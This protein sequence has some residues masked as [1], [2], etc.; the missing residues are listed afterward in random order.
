MTSIHRVARA[1]LSVAMAV[2]VVAPASA[3]QPNCPPAR[4]REI[5]Q[6]GGPC[7]IGALTLAD[8][9]ALAQKQGLTAEA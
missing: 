7:P 5:V 9:V 1:A 2:L 4:Q 8:A 3:Q 6:A